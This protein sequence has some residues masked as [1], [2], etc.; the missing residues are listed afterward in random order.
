LELF[1]VPCQV[2]LKFQPLEYVVRPALPFG[3]R[4]E[5]FSFGN[6]VY[7]LFATVTEVFGTVIRRTGGVIYQI[8]LKIRE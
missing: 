3:I 8:L 5:S 7:D 1:S 4:N 6:E 2:G